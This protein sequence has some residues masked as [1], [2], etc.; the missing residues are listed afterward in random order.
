MGS[1][2]TNFT[3]TP[4]AA[5]SGTITITPSGGGLSTAM[6]LTFSNS[7]AAQTFTITPTA[8]GPVTLTPSNSGSLANASALSYAT[9]PAAPTIGAAV[10][11][12]GSASVAFTAPG[13]TGGSAITG[14]TAICSPGNITGTGTTSPITVSP[15]TNGTPYTCTVTATNTYGPSAASGASNGVTPA[16]P[17]TGYTLNGP[18]GGAVGSASTNFTVTP[19]AAYSG[20][21]TITPSGGGLSTAMVLTFSNSAAAQT[22][23]ITPTAVGPVTL[24]PSNSG[25]LANASALSYATNPAAPTIGAAVAGNGSASVAFTPP[26]NTGG[27]AIT[28]YTASCSPGNLTGTAASSPVTIWGLTNG[29][30][31]TCTVTATNGYGT[32]VSSSASPSVTP[33]A[34]AGQGL[35]LQ[36]STF[37]V[38]VEGTQYPLQILTATGGVAPYL[39]SIGSGALPGGLSFASPQFTGIPTTSGDFLFTVTVTD[40]AGN[41]ANAA[42]SILIN[43]VGVDLILSQSTV[44]F[45]SRDDGIPGGLTDTCQRH[46]AVQRHP[47]NPELRRYRVSGSPMAKRAW[48]R[49]HSREHSYR[50]LPSRAHASP[51]HQRVSNHRN[52]NLCPP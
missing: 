12:N 48:W 17:A 22:F 6:V 27:A 35:A 47:A 8:V 44:S 37:P 19:N 25:S 2:S 28:G 50:S 21:I 14:Y 5:Y 4:N 39:F 52:G 13:N 43:P 9:N 24:T 3:V 11:G 1:A 36:V 34:G 15:L 33:S 30:A 16:S 46:G 32:S 29:T 7:A 20:T 26:A 31:Y 42:S 49:N 45:I 40:S 41:R 38:G 51:G 23:T 18:A 10:A